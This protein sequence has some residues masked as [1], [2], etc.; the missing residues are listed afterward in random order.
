MGYDLD[1][2][3]IIEQ[4]MSIPVI[5][6][7]GAGKLEPFF[8]AFN[9]GADAVCTNNIYHFTEKSIQNAKIFLKN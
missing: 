6:S 2:L 4:R 9:N 3:K 5:I 7:G 8:E 1:L